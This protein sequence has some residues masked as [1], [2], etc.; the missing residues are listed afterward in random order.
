MMSQKSVSQN[1]LSAILNKQESTL[2]SEWIKEQSSV[3][4][5]QGAV[6]KESELR[7]Q[8]SEFLRLLRASLEQG[9][10][11][12]IESPQWKGV[13]EML[14]E[15]SQSRVALGFSPSETASFIFSLKRPVFAAI[16]RELAGDPQALADETW[17]SSELLDKLGLFTTEAY[18]SM[19]EAI[20]N[21]Q[22]QEMMELST[23]VVKL[24]EGILALP[25][26]GTLDSARTQLVM[27]NLLQRILE[28]GSA[29]AIIDITG[30]PTVDTLTAQH[31][32][33]AVTAARL[34]GA[35]CIISGIRPQIAQ[36]IVHLG[37]DLGD[38]T[39][40]A[41]LADAFALALD[42]TGRTVT[43]IKSGHE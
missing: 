9:K 38:V 13:R 35:D 3:Q 14:E 30:V 28:T 10:E 27:E 20:I 16:R 29:I 40:K 19:R 18:Q 31:L 42:R 4:G 22:Q 33:K 2:L 5:R 11:A 32:L 6:L 34:M 8:C 24:W 36:T 43:R 1:G 17:S 37:V 23:P 39:T 41:S 12:D 26:I 25:M 21:R 15:L 7:K